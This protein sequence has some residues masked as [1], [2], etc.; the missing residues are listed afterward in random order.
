MSDNKRNIN[1]YLQSSSNRGWDSGFEGAGSAENSD[2]LLFGRISE[3]FKGEADIADV[4]N[5]PNLSEIEGIA[6]EIINN[7]RNKVPDNQVRNFVQDNLSDQIDNLQVNRELRE[8]L[9]EISDN[10]VNSITSEWVRE[11]HNKHQVSEKGELKAND[12]I[13]EFIKKSLEPAEAETT[14]VKASESSD[15][16]THKRFSTLARY[17]ILAVAAVIAVFFTMRIFIWQTD[18]NRI[19]KDFYSPY[20]VLSDVTRNGTDPSAVINENKLA[21]LYRNGNYSGV[22]NANGSS[23]IPAV[24][25]ISA[26]FWTGLSYL[27]LKDFDQAI[28]FLSPVADSSADISKDA[29][30]YLGLAYIMKGDKANAIRYLETLSG[31]RGYYQKPS[32]KLLR[33]LK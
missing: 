20:P 21:E 3:F 9:Q 26:N 18:A 29:S 17:S 31:T 33:R 22:I 28:V 15:I 1:A 16:K 12:E 8:V 2:A 23:E 27:H 4:E 11:W 14:S 10:D 32:L 30:W 5:D 24:E 6:T 25:D 7:F 19:F 13:R